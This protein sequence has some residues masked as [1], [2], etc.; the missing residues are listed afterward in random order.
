MQF[1]EIK[2]KKKRNTLEYL[3][4]NYISLLAYYWI[5]AVHYPR[6]DIVPWSSGWEPLT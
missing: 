4:G 6:P 5:F 1:K 2:F 3:Y